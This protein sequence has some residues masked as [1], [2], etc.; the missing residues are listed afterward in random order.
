[1]R[2]ARLLA[3][4]KVGSDVIQSAV[5]LEVQRKVLGAWG[6]ESEVVPGGVNRV[7]AGAATCIVQCRFPDCMKGSCVGHE[8]PV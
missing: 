8:A 3:V 2:L 1:M 7:L 4:Q 6:L 5:S